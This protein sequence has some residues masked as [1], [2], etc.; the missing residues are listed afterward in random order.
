MNP[1][2]RLDSMNLVT[3]CHQTESAVI[4]APV[5]KVWEVIKNFKF[6]A[7]IIKELKF[8]TGGPTELGSVFE[9]TYEDGSVWMNRITELSESHRLISYELLSAEP[10]VTF[11]SR[12]ITIRLYR[13]SEDNT[14]FIQLST[15]FSNDVDSH[16]IQD[17]KFKKLECFKELKKFIAQN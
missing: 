1:I 8:V 15:E 13:V 7:S 6:H 5:G 12:V 3:S 16:I 4:P 10:N 11:S 14:T 2:T 17:T 9:V